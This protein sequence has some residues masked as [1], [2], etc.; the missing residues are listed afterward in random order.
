[1]TG[2][3]ALRLAALEAEGRIRAVMARYMELCDRLDQ[4]TPMDEMAAL[5][6]EGATWA[7]RGARYGA[8]F[9]ERRG[10]AAIL[11][12]LD[13]YRAPAPHFAFNAH[14]LASEAITVDGAAASG[15]WMMLQLSTYADGRSDLRTARLRVGFALDG[16]AWRIDRFETE[17]L[18][19]RPVDRWD[20]P[21]P[22]PVPRPP[23][24]GA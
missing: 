19:S 6:T 12:M 7:G 10:R 3:L 11:A 21:A 1:M 24:Q 5:F 8:A 13:S 4:D 22:P 9:G 15:G 17:A 16:G 23:S 20:D 14:F 2:A 18:S